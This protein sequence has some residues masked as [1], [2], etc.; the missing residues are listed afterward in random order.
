MDERPVQEVYDLKL[1]SGNIILKNETISDDDMET[2]ECTKCLERYEDINEA[3]EVL[4][5]YR[6]TAL[7][8]DGAISVSAYG[9]ETM[10]FEGEEYISTGR[11]VY[12]PFDE[13]SVISREE[14]V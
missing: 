6:S 9:I 4:D 8:E 13:S 1:F 14:T 7:S 5:E 10:R 3:M 11:I 12:A 2:L